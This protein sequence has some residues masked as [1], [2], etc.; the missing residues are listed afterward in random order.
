MKKMQM[1]LSS[2][3]IMMLLSFVLTYLMTY[4]MIDQVKDFTFNLNLF[5]QALFMGLAMGAIETGMMLSVHSDKFLRGLFL[6]LL[7]G[8]LFLLIL[9]R[10]QIGVNQE[11]FLRAMSQVSPRTTD[12]N[13][14]R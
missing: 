4:A 8:S 10:Y 12:P 1:N 7:L 2:I 14:L 11:E 9:I 5:Y 3:W 13:I 6:F